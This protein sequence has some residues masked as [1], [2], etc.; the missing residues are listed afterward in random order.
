ML[1]NL[2]KSF[3]IDF[4]AVFENNVTDIVFMLPYSP[5][6]FYPKNC[7]RIDAFYIASNTLYK[8]VK[9]ISKL[10]QEKGYTVLD[11][12]LQLKKVAEKGGLGSILHNQL[13][14]NNKYGSRTTLQA[15]SVIGEYE[16]IADGKVDIICDKCHRCDMA[17][18]QNALSNGSFMR[19]RCLRHKQDFCAEF[20]DDK[21]GRT[22]GCE[23]CQNS[24]PF[25]SNVKKIT[26]PSEVAKVFDYNNLFDMLSCG[27]K[28]LTPLAELIGSNMA[29]TAFVFNLVVNGLMS[30]NNFLYTSRIESFENHTNESIKNKVQDYKLRE[31]L[32]LK[33]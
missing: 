21:V 26:M 19:D 10:L 32:K 22:L 7:A 11:R 5:Y 4:C 30:S 23:E 27:K 3:N 25:N 9:E 24:C 8:K 28:A 12:H 29:R 31:R 1:I 33:S 18:P 15:V 20:F 2:L 16:Y 17:C 13:L 14:V 6:E